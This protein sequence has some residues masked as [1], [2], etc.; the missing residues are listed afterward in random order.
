VAHYRL[1]HPYARLTEVDLLGTLAKMQLKHAPGSQREYSNFALMV[2]S[3][4]LAKHSG[5]D[6]ETLLRS[7]LLSPLGMDDTYIVRRPPSVRAAQGHFS[8]GKPTGPWGVRVDLAGAW[9]C[10]RNP[11]RHGALS[12]RSARHAR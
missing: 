5:S 1:E 4:A 7:R 2:L 8:N 12:R 6:F 10:A 3:Y 9:R 11:A